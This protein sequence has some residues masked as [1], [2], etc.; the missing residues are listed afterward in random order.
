MNTQGA[1]APLAAPLSDQ[2]R[3]CQTFA[4]RGKPRH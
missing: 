1:V 3:C 2:D 4:W